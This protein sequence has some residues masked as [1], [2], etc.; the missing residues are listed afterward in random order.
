M[1]ALVR[2]EVMK[3]RTTRLALVLMACSGLLA[4]LGALAMILTAGQPQALDL[5][6]H[7][8]VLAIYAAAS[9]GT[10]LALVLGVVIVTA[11]YRHGTITG[12]LLVQ[13][14]RGGVLAAK[15]VTGV[16]A[17]LA[18]ALVSTVAT[19]AVALPGLALH[20][21]VAPVGAGEVAGVLAGSAASVAV[22]GAIGVAIGALVTNQVAAIVVALVWTSLVEGSLVAFLP[23]VGR[24]LPSGAAAALAQSG[25]GDMLAVWAGGL[26]FLA[27]AAAAALVA[28]RPFIRRDVT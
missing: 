20:G 16:L 21:D 1:C 18:F 15:V 5:S 23:D 13:P 6:R 17:G 8:D 25:E 11:E 7:A 9:G 24:W 3:L 27:Y 19:L 2:A 26:L 12:T 14:R 10:P 4:G 22:W 28:A